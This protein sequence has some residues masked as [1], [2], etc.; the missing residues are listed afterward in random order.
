MGKVIVIGSGFA[1]LSAAACLAKEGHEVTVLEKNDSLGGRARM[2]EV[3]GFKF[4]MGPSWYWMPD[5][6]E[7]YYNLFGKTTS[8][9]YQ[10]KRLDPSYNVVWQDQSNWLIPTGQEA[11]ETFFEKQEAGAG[12]QLREFL[13]QAQFKYEV[14]IQELVY[15]PG[16]SLLEFMDLRLLYGL[17]KMDV[18]TSMSKHIRKFFKNPK[19]IELAE[20]PVLFL[21]AKP[22]DTP[23]LYSLM[24]YADMTLG[25]WYPDGG[26]FEIV[27]AMVSIA[28]EQGVKFITNAEVTSFVYDK[29]TISGVKT[30]EQ[31]YECDIVV[32]AADYH[33]IE[34][35]VLDS[36]HHHYSQAYWD[37]REMAPSSIIYYLGID[38]KIDKLQHHNLFFDSDFKLHAEEIYTDPKWPTDPLFYVCCPSKSDASVAPAGKENIF[39][40]IPTA[41][42]LLDDDQV[43]DKYFDM[44]LDRMEKYCGTD[45]KNHIVYKRS[46]AARDFISNY[47]S[48]KGNAYGLA[49]TLR[50]TAILKPSIKS[51][52]LSNLYFAGQLTVPGPGVPPSIISGQV[53]AQEIKD[54]LN[55]D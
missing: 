6:F 24:N 53:V 27:K 43:L 49:N 37:K 29:K 7:N 16:Q 52:K 44:V 42:G 46:F 54:D 21:G 34:H 23:A 19:L 1:G 48:F 32:A 39:I 45:I 14:G 30:G 25:T 11:L 28:K 9:F 35:D 2:F 18:F 3:D 26:M 12:L 36:T 13:K 17:F 51:A 47:H 55:N 40:L 22:E 50:Q 15:K 10:L 33:H 41:P 20:F 4:D 38:K 5:V 31:I 8:D